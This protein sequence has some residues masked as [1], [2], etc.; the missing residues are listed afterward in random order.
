MIQGRSHSWPSLQMVGRW[1]CVPIQ[2]GSPIPG[3]HFYWRVWS[4]RSWSYLDG[5]HL[6]PLP[7]KAF[8][9]VKESAFTERFGDLDATEMVR[10][11]SVG[12]SRGGQIVDSW[13]T[14][15]SQWEGPRNR[16]I[17][18][19]RLSCAGPSGARDAQTTTNRAEPSR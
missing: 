1:S 13:V 14:S 2:F 6:I 15:I 8:R 9:S 7:W 3:A 12:L 11:P 5:D 10:C 17:R 19:R 18:V 16:I 4:F